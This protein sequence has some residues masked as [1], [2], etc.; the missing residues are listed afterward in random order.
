RDFIESGVEISGIPF[1][2]VD[3][4]GFRDAAD[5]LEHLGI[6]LTEKKVSE[7]D[8]LLIVIDW[9]RPLSRED[10]DILLRA[11]GMQAILVL[12]KT[13]LPCNPREAS[14]LEILPALPRVSISALTGKGIDDLRKTMAKTVLRD[15]QEAPLETVGPNLRQQQALKQALDFFTASLKG[16]RE[17]VPLEIIA[18]ELKSGLDALGEIIGET[19]NED[20]LES[21]FSRFCLGK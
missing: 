21:I 4:A 5:D 11:D 19:T 14:D 6:N 9:S 17:G 15:G 10:R 20:I 13:D 7:A 2:L 12:N 8:L 16:T 18:L 3:T 1:R